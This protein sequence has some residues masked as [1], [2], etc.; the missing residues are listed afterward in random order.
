MYNHFILYLTTKKR[1]FKIAIIKNN[2]YQCS[3]ENKL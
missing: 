1:A 2:Q 3:F